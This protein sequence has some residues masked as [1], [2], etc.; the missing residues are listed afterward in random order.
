M[1]RKSKRVRR[2]VKG[3][4]VKT[5]EVWVIKRYKFNDLLREFL[6]KKHFKDDDIF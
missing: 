1:E 6:T 5:E 3:K 4:K 2:V